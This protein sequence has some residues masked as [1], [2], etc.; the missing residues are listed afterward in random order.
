LTEGLVPPQNWAGRSAI[1]EEL[2]KTKATP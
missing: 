1:A 2:L